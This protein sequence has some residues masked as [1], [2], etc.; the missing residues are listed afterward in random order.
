MTP[1]ERGSI[2]E[3]LCKWRSVF[4]GWQLG[5]RPDS[6]PECKAVRDHREVTML[7]RAELN[8]LT[9]LLINHKVFSQNEFSDQ[10][11]VEAGLL[12]KQYEEKFPGFSTTEYGV[13]INPQVARETTKGWRP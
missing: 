4:A 11:A 7:M 12:D 9:Q 1:S 13:V 5:T 10:V 3:K 2:L 8:A 6:D